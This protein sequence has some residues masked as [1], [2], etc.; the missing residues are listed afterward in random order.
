VQPYRL[1]EQEAVRERVARYAG[2]GPRYTS[3][4]TAPVW[5]DSF[6]AR[7]LARALGRQS[8]A[9]L[10]IYVHIPYCERLCTYCACNR[11]ISRD[12]S[13][14]G[15]FLDTLEREFALVKKCLG[16]SR[17]RVQLA[18][19][20]GTPTYLSVGE[21]DR[22]GRALEQTYPGER[23][24]EA[25]VEVD[26]RVTTRVQLEVLAEHGFNRISLGVQ[27]LAPR[28][29]QA[30][31]RIQSC[32][33]TESVATWARELGYGS[34][35]FDLIYGLP[36]QN[37]ESFSGTLDEVIRMRPDRIAL[38]SYAHVTWVSKQ[39]RGFDRHDLPSGQQKLE[40]LLLAIQRLCEAGYIY[41]GLD[42]F[43]VPEDALAQ[44]AEIGNLRRNFM[45]YTTQRD[46]ELCA[47]GPSGITELHDVYAQSVRTPEEW[48][49]RIQAGQLPTLRGVQLSAADLWRKWLIQELMCAGSISATAFE[50]RFGIPLDAGVP[51]AAERLRP[52]AE[53]GLLEAPAS[54]CGTDTRDVEYR[55]TPLGRLFL[56]NIAMSFDAYLERET[57]ATP[58]FSSTI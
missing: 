17:T 36:F 22:L 28:V 1:P 15:P 11:V 3:Y 50:R 49:A 4:P 7:E 18:L 16:D 37:V 13:V 19:G 44:A 43:V 45:G 27:D 38:Y 39:Q 42:H 58:R 54:A 12:R 35:H 47:F 14:V 32:E 56:R 6:D 52:L 48:S 34:V 24:S 46:T 5:R 2:S 55:V 40:I 10:S 26:P 53:D 9:P 23:G 8:D 25:S 41:L 30:I 21:L 20:G 29:Q 33:Q 31:R 57:G 51:E